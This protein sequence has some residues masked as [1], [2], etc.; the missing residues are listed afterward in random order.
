[1]KPPPNLKPSEPLSQVVFIHDYLQL[2][3]H[4]EV[5]SIYNLAEVDLRG[6]KVTRGQQGF[7][8]AV[9]SLIGQRVTTASH[10]DGYALRLSFEKGAQFN[11]RSDDAAVSGPEAFAF[12]GKDQ[13]PVVEQ[14]A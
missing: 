13:P 12:N 3:F 2:V 8:D 14:N 11:V 6:V 1:M 10:S 7:C 4:E 9:V 5:F